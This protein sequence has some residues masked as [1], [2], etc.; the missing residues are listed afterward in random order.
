MTGSS[1][2]AR[3]TTP[4]A[5]PATLRPGPGL[6][7]AGLPGSFGQSARLARLTHCSPVAVSKKDLISKVAK[8][9]G[10]EKDV[11]EKVVN[12]TIEA[13]M[14]Y[15]ADGEKVQVPGFGSYEPRVRS[16]RKGRNPK[17]GEELDIAE[18]RVPAFTAGKVFKELVNDA[19]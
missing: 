8:D 14:S 9:A 17:T 11:A 4:R 7:A 12:A 13:I 5:P 3:I 19:K 2:A 10:V 6:R 16:A 1:C 15:V 18:K